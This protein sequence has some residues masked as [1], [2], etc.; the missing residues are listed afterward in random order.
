MGAKTL[1]HMWQFF[2]IPNHKAIP[3]IKTDIGNCGQFYLNISITMDQTIP[4]VR[5]TQQVILG[6]MQ[7]NIYFTT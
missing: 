7:L 4:I 2:S 5:W 6:W 3:R 1:I